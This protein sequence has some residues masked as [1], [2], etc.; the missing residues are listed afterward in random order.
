MKINEEKFG[1]I[2]K[3]SYLCCENRYGFLQIIRT[4]TGK[5]MSIADT[6][7]NKILRSPKDT[8]FFIGSFPQFDEEYVRQVYVEMLSSGRLKRIGKGIYYVPQITRFGPVLP[9]VNNVAKAIAKRDRAKIMPTGA[10]AQN[11]LG[12][13]TQLP[14]N[15]VYLTTGSSRNIKLENGQSIRFVHAAPRNFAYKGEVMPI[16]VQALKEYGSAL[17]SLTEEELG[18]L[19]NVLRQHP[20]ESTIEHDLQLAP[21]KIRKMLRTII[22]NIKTQNATL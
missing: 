21:I 3:T 13:S 7:R 2:E 4:T 18:A 16:I 15:V 9:T 22:N 8:I 19:Y 1:N 14:M 20:E 11:M 6:I 17:D 12:M 5:R 10:A